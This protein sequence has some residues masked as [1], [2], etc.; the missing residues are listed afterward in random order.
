MSREKK[1]CLISIT[2]I[3]PKGLNIT[4]SKNSITENGNKLNSL[5]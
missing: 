2:D 3:V 5:Y 1:E 4:T